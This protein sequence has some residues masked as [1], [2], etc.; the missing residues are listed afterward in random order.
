MSGPRRAPPCPHSGV[1]SGEGGPRLVGVGVQKKGGGRRQGQRLEVQSHLCFTRCALFPIWF[2]PQ[3]CIPVDH[4]PF[5]RLN[6]YE[7]EI[8]LFATC[9]QIWN[10]FARMMYEFFSICMLICYGI[11]WSK[12]DLLVQNSVCMILLHN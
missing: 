7:S 6:I 5:F 12:W 4:V 8:L 2:A 1:S 11:L 10:S 3:T 9:S